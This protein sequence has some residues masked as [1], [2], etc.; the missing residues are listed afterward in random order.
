M[1]NN[2]RLKHY[3]FIDVRNISKSFN[4]KL[5]FEDGTFYIS[6]TCRVG[7]VGENGAG[8]ST[9]LKIL[10]KQENPD[11]GVIVHSKKLSVSYFS[12]E[13]LP[14]KNNSTV[15]E[16]ILRET[17][18]SSKV[19]LN[20]N[21]LAILDGLKITTQLKTSM[22][23]LSLG[24][25][26]KVLLAVALLR[27]ADM[28]LLDEPT[29]NLDL[30]TL[31]WL[32]KYLLHQTKILIFVTHNQEF[33]ESIAD[34]IIEVS[35]Q[36]KRLTVVNGSYTAYLE[37]RSAVEEN[38]E[39][40][41]KNQARKI[42]RLKSA[43][44]QKESE[45]YKGSTFIGDDNDKFLRGANRE[46]AGKSGRAIKTMR[47][48][49]EREKVPEKLRNRQALK[50][51]V[52]DD[53]RSAGDITLTNVDFGYKKEEPV[54]KG[55]NLRI[56]FGQKMLLLGGNGTGKT[57]FLKTITGSL[58]ELGGLIQKEK[59]VRIGNF[60]QSYDELQG[61][62]SVGEF[63]Q[64]KYALNKEQI[65]EQLSLYQ[66][67]SRTYTQTLSSLSLGEKARLLFVTFNLRGCN[68]LVLDEPTNSLD[69]ETAR[70]L[71]V[72]LED[73]EG[74][75]LLST[76]DEHFLKNF[77]ATDIFYIEEQ[78]LVRIYDINKYIDRLKST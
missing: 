44:K 67:E 68:T 42:S 62:K 32:K 3:M 19:S 76:H 27:N 45:F 24:Q 60:S 56:S 18:L 17:E 14:I 53:V 29:N 6:D 35:T 48:R 61:H 59:A 38:Q 72:F 63:L 40:V 43:I 2:A 50:L 52:D 47:A 7:V 30:A 71:E 78:K 13:H 31:L 65:Y 74:T 33:L 41:R 25:Q 46:R 57:T 4:E 34:K 51:F 16:Y 15:L 28:L 12:A 36:E 23:T 69:L 75:V 9:L 58:K 26:A 49:V 77:T 55:V 73:F 22:R 70:A 64:K 66:F 54:L 39:A 21:E 37:Q 20:K 5:L 8:K 11:T 1:Q 10:A